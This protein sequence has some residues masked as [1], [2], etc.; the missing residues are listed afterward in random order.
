[1]VDCRSCEGL[2]RCVA[3]HVASPRG[4]CRQRW[5]MT[6]H[7]VWCGAGGR[8]L[9]HGHQQ[10]GRAHARCPNSLPCGTLRR[11][12]SWL[13]RHRCVLHKSTLM[14]GTRIYSQLLPRAHCSVATGMTPCTRARVLKCPVPQVR[15]HQR[16][17]SGTRRSSRSRAPSRRRSTTT[18]PWCAC[19]QPPASL[20][21]SCSCT[22]SS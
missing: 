18:A 16:T 10:D 8:G 17:S 15:C 14:F 9:L 20:P 13:A 19:F 12:P 11:N 7:G 2:P 21:S 22:A 1:M 4:R 3:M 6:C 5:L